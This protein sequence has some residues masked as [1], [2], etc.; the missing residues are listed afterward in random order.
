MDYL[1]QYMSVQTIVVSIVVWAITTA[2]QWM[3]CQKAG[4]HGWASIVPFYSDYIL[5]KIAWGNGWLFLVGF[6]PIV[7]FFF[8]VIVMFKLSRAFG[9]GFGYG[10][11]LLFLPVVFYPILGFGSDQYSFPAKYR[12][13]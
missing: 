5:F 6:I 13:A 3:V 8:D 12:E 2:G 9:H 7:G 11:G 4:E 10:L 1:E